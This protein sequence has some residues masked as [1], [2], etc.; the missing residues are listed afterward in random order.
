MFDSHRNI[1]QRIFVMNRFSLVAAFAAC[2]FCGAAAA[3]DKSV[4]F[5]SLDWPPFSGGTLPDQGVFI[6]VVRDA[7]AK[8][9]YKVEVTFLPWK[10]AVETATNDASYAGLLPIYPDDLTP[11]FF[12]STVVMDS[13]LGFAERAEKPL[14]WSTLDDLKGRRLGV[15]MG[16]S[17]TPE[18]DAAVAD[19]RLKT[20]EAGDD[21]TNL[22]KLAAGRVDAAVVDLYVLDHLL[23]SSPELKPYKAALRFSAKPLAD[24]P[25]LIG[26]RDAPIGRE[27]DAALKEGLAKVDV[28]SALR[29]LLAS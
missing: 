21:L 22:R 17:N 19:K 7:L 24:K 3:Q 11:G 6:G 2:L 23:D 20:D 26:L 13:P 8:Q 15:V 25:I 29:K 12:G 10:R 28:K 16:Y 5:T 14:V 18:F 27:I 9:G 1:Q 4:K